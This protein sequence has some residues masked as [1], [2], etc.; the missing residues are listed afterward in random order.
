MQFERRSITRTTYASVR[1][2]NASVAVMTERTDGGEPGERRPVSCLL[3]AHEPP[4]KPR[5]RG[6]VVNVRLDAQSVRDLYVGLRGVL[7]AMAPEL[8][9]QA[10]A[11]VAE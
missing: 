9:A 10:D 11:E 8:R 1:R 4:L 7:D 5:G 6:D 2:N 3:V